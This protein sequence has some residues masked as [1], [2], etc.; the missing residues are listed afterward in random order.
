M[1]KIKSWIIRAGDCDRRDGR[2]K[3]VLQMCFLF[4]MPVFVYLPMVGL[5]PFELS[6][7]IP[8]HTTVR[9]TAVGLT[10]AGVVILIYLSTL[11]VEA[12]LGKIS[13]ALKSH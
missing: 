3:R 9:A 4:S 13:G 12:L 6:G 11:A 10:L 1:G 8:N 5:D 2:T 7:M